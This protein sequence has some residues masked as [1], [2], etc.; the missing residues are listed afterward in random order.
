[1]KASFYF[2]WLFLSLL[3][4]CISV[5]AQNDTSKID[6]ASLPKLKP[7]IEKLK[8]KQQPGLAL[9]ASKIFF[10]DKRYSISGFGE[11]N[12][13]SYDGAKDR[14]VG[15]MELYYTN[16]YR[17]ATFFGYRFTDKII[18]NSEFQ[19]EYLH[20]GTRE[21]RA[22][23]VIEAFVDFLIHEKFKARL[24]FYPLP[25]G[26]VNNN[27]EPVMFYAVNRSEVERIITPSTW[28][29]FGTMFYGNL[30]KNWSYA[31]GIS[32][33]LNAR[34]YLSGTWVRQGREIRLDVPQS[35]AINPQITYSGFKNLTI[36]ASGYFGNSGQGAEVWAGSG[37]KE[38]K[39]PIRLATGYAKFEPGNWRF[40]A[41]GVYGE[42]GNTYEIEQLTRTSFT[43]P[44]QVIGREVYGAMAELG[45]DFLP[46]LRGSNP[47]KN[48]EKWYFKSH[49]IKL[50]VFLRYER[51][52]THSSIDPRLQNLTRVQN[53]LDIWTVGFN[54]NTRENIVLKANYQ[55]RNN[56]YK[57]TRVP[58]SNITELGLGFIF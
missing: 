27:D 50:P 11:V 34:N 36:S 35:I 56:R 15:D 54:F 40:I 5:F 1:M 51:L 41:L 10:S 38:I 49:E 46:L 43:A 9:A 4:S 18:W 25:I 29:E 16:L 20:D 31:L 30:S 24:G 13:V 58:E 2:V 19:I 57:Q 17:F 42:L 12:F 6:T 33:G 55:F 47:H 21:G 26:Y 22:E 8:Y 45:Y 23:I 14:T 52:N 48:I 39:A 53:D 7:E 3:F 32:Q 44:G 37:Q 28:I